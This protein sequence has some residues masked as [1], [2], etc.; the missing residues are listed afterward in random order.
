MNTVIDMLGQVTSTGW[1]A[2]S[3]AFSATPA[4]A[5]AITQY[6]PQIIQANSLFGGLNIADAPLPF[7][8]V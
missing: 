1:S 7:R 3:S 4:V 2:V 6:S 8:C 5:N